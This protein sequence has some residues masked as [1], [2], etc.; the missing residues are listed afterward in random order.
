MYSEAPILE[1]GSLLSAQLPPQLPNSL[2]FLYQPK[3]HVGFHKQMILS[4]V[5]SHDSQE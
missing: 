4:T 5:H 3:A 1:A 2:K